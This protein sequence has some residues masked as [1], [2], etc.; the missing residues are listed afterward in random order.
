MKKIFLCLLAIVILLVC[1]SLGFYYVQKTVDNNGTTFN[2][3]TSDENDDAWNTFVEGEKMSMSS[4]A[5]DHSSSSDNTSSKSTITSSTN[6]YEEQRSR[7]VYATLAE[8]P[9]EKMESMRSVYNYMD[10]DLAK[11]AFV[12]TAKDWSQKMWDIRSYDAKEDFIDHMHISDREMLR[13]YEPSM[14]DFIDN[15]HDRYPDYTITRKRQ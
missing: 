14:K 6:S 4:S 5:Q 3:T 1:G 2:S 15:F 8:I 9:E 13:L 12:F 7:L 11:R 10:P